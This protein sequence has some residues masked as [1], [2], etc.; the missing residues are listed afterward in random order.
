M[1]SLVFLAVWLAFLH[2][3]FVLVAAP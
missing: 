1:A 3:I 2:K